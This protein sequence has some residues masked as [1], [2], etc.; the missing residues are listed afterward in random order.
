MRKGL[1]L[2]AG[3]AMSAATAVAAQSA[4]TASIRGLVYDS[5][6]GRGALAGASVELLELGRVVRTTAQGLFR[7]D[8]L[9]AGTYTIFFTDSALSSI[10]FSLPDR[11][12]RVSE[13]IDVAT[14]LATPSG[15]T[16]Y[17]VLCRNTPEPSTGVLLG[18]LTDA[19][20]GQPVRGGEVR[21]DWVVATLDRTAGFVRRPQVVR[22]AV[23]SSGRYQ[24]CGVPTDVPVLLRATA[25]GVQ[26][27]PLDLRLADRAFDV[28]HLSLD[29]SPDSAGVAVLTGVVRSGGDPVSNAQ[30]LVLG[31][32]TVARTDEQG[33][34]RLERLKAG[35]HSVEARA[36]G[37][38]RQRQTIE[39]HG[40]RP[41]SIELAL[42]R[43]AVELPEIAVKAPETAGL[44][45]FEERRRRGGFGRYITKEDVLLRQ[46]VRT[47]DLFKTV[48]GMRVEPVGQTEYRLLSTRG[49]PGFSTVC[50]PTVFIDDIRLPLD[51]EN[52][53][54]IPVQ[55]QELEGIEVY[56]GAGSIPIQYRAVGQNCGVI[57]IWTK[58]GQR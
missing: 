19:R 1:V 50:E 6:L 36:I 43:Q 23:D 4:P 25:V 51:P 45:G 40:D 10:G 21:G 2:F 22:A 16:I 52:G 18:T 5:L 35:T 31:V 20:T 37:F 26:G 30:V 39:L 57:L 12:V 17:R 38:T 58:R 55:P 28:R 54:T 33:R 11:E 46:P 42:E 56:Q 14:T 27:P 29:L 8:S 44:S 15:P 34:F 3:L 32:E 53:L 24:L 13:G 49:G 7:F 47:E 48:P 41:V 9:P